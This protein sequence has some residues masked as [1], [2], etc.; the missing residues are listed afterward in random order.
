M[1]M[2]FPAPY[3]HG[4]GNGTRIRCG[5]VAVLRPLPC[6]YGTDD[7]TRIRCGTDDGTGIRCSTDCWLWYHQRR[8]YT[9]AEGTCDSRTMRTRSHRVSTGMRDRHLG[10]GIR[11]RCSSTD[12]R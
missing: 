7:G 6:L 1:A 11:C 5:T 12:M 3:Q 4:T 10:A 2:V 8:T 9:Q